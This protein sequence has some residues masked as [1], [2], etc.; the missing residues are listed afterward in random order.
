MAPSI[1]TPAPGFMKFTIL[2][3]LSLVII[4]IYRICVIHTLVYTKRGQEEVHFH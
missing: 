2:V 4:T 1:R 3:D